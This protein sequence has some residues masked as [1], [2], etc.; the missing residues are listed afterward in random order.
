MVCLECFFSED[1][2]LLLLLPVFPD[3]LVGTPLVRAFA[4]KFDELFDG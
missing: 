1:T 2:D 4:V 3:I